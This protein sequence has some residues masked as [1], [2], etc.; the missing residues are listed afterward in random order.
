MILDGDNTPQY[1]QT[2]P[3]VPIATA[4]VVWTVIFPLLSRHQDHN[5]RNIQL[6]IE[7]VQL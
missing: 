5:K 2:K 1:T 4:P 3:A 7:G 6:Q